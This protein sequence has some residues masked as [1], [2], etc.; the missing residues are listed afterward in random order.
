MWSDA[1][2]RVTER[3]PRQRRNSRSLGPVGL[4][5]CR[6]SSTSILTKRIGTNSTAIISAVLPI[7]RLDSFNQV[8]RRSC[9]ENR[10][11]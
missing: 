1:S 2:R 6:N 8:K 4:V 3:W 11:S 10:R 9:K 7:K 5:M